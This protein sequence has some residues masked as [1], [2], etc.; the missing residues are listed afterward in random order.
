MYSFDHARPE[1]LPRLADLLGLLFAQEA[2]FR[3]D[4]ERQLRALRLILEDPGTGR[5]YCA[6]AREEAVGLVS[7][8]FTVSTAEGGRAGWL[9]DMVVHPDH[10]GRGLGTRLL[11]HALA[12]AREL[13]CSR[14]TLLTDT[15]NEA[16]QRLYARE[17]FAR[18]AMLP[19]RRA[20]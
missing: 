11:R 2:D 15:T 4:R 18:S 3:P 5:L 9:E 14:L 13:G 7:V 20:L 6:R 10:R 19:M 12:Q 1:D 8:L 17:G 16:A